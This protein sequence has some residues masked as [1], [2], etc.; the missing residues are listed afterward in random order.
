M[1]VSAAGAEQVIA[2]F[3]GTVP[4][5]K[6]ANSMA[7]W[8]TVATMMV[9]WKEG[10]QMTVEETL[11]KAGAQYLTKFQNGEGLLSSEKEAFIGALGMVGEAPASYSLQQYIDWVNTYGP[12]WITTDSSAAAGQF[13]PHARVVTRITGTGSADG[14]GTSFV[15]IDP[16]SG[17]ELT[18][19]FSTF[20]SAYEQMVT[21]N[22]GDLFIQIVHFPTRRAVGRVAPR[23]RRCR[24]GPTLS[25]RSSVP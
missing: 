14:S 24:P 12:L 2:K 11:Q 4:K 16:A 3:S 8:A 23:S 20:L 15:F 17:T 13:S 19:P 18:E 22:P 6:Q 21:D 7:C 25:I 10:R 9:S 1:E 5:L